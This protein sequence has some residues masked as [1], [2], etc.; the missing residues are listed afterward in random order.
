MT[1]KQ[2]SA[3][4]GPLLMTLAMAGFAIEDALIK[5]I[6]ARLPVGQIAVI[7][8]AG[9]ALVFWVLMRG[10]GLFDRR[11]LQGIIGL[12]N[13]AEALAAACMMLGIALV[14]LSVVSAILQ[15]MPLAVTLAAAVILKESVGWR[16]WSAIIIG[17][18]GVMLILRPGTAAFDWTLLLPLGAV[19]FLTVRDL[20]TRRMPADVGSLQ[21]SG[22]GFLA[23]IP[24]GLML[25]AIR[26]EAPAVPGLVDSALLLACIVVG[27]AAYGALVLATRSG[28]IGLTTPFRYT[29]LVFAMLIGVVVFAER[30][31]APTLIGAAI[32]VAAGLYTLMREMKVKRGRG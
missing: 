8:G 26:G 25:L 17:F 4:R 2:V 9:G 11:A 20:A 3:L 28:D 18:G 6:S 5:D 15:V 19:V 21:I 32:V 14:P 29:R 1:S 24:A 30:P 7:L 27:V 31:D 12:R 13:G 22:W 10:R 23:V 16:R